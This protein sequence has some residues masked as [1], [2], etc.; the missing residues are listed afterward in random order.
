MTRPKCI[1]EYWDTAEN[2]TQM[3]W[4]SEWQCNCQTTDSI[5]S[6]YGESSGNYLFGF[7]L[8]VCFDGPVKKLMFRVSK[9]KILNW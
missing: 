2:G 1:K 7:T 3:P 5:A 8:T 9:K 6:S 4:V